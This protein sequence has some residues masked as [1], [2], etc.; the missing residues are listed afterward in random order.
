MQVLPLHFYFSWLKRHIP[1]ASPSM[2]R[3]ETLLCNVVWR[4][5]CYRGTCCIR[6][7]RE[8]FYLSTYTDRAHTSEHTPA[9][10]LPLC[11]SGGE[12]LAGARGR[13]ES[14][15]R[16]GQ[17]PGWCAAEREGVGAT[18]GACGWYEG[19]PPLQPLQC[20]CSDQQRRSTGSWA[21]VR[22]G[23]Q[24]SSASGM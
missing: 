23:G 9:T 8:F 3:A 18:R 20:G 21:D 12:R 14:G 11:V 10:V 4:A 24:C 16:C 6:Q 2:G 17:V 13:A 15:A 7:H 19:R 1:V 22:S 5:R